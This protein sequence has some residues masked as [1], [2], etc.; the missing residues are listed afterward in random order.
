MKN[1][2]QKNIS[3]DRYPKQGSYLNKRVGVI[4][5][6]EMEC[7]IEGEVIRDDIEHP[8]SMIIKLDNGWVVSSIECQYRP[9]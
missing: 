7:E 9:L 3:S 4:F 6:F 8:W 5:N 1:S 2:N